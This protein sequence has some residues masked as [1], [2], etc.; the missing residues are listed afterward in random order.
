MVDNEE[1]KGE[2][3]LSSDTR[4]FQ[5]GNWVL[6][7]SARS[8]LR[9]PRRNGTDPREESVGKWFSR[10]TRYLL[11]AAPFT[12]DYLRGEIVSKRFRDE[13]R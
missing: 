6:N 7:Y 10:F 1:E 13:N 3:C 2:A 4:V 12:R 8:I 11:F 9:Y 5:R